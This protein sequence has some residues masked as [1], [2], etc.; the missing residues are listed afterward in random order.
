MG[1]SSYISPEQTEVFPANSLTIDMF[2]S[3]LYRG[4]EF[5]ADDHVA[6]LNNSRGVYSRYA[7]QFIQPNIE[8]AISGKYDYSRN[9]YASDAPGIVVNLPAT[10]SGELDLNFM[11]TYVKAQQKL[12]IKNVVEWREKYISETKRVITTI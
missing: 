9:F 12:T 10:A 3:V 6:V 2:G 5:G 7:L 1:I 11:E 8:K 4:Y